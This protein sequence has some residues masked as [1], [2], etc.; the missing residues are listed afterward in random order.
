M[1]QEFAEALGAR[2]PADIPGLATPQTGYRL[3]IDAAQFTGGADSATACIDWV[4]AHGGTAVRREA[5][6]FNWAT[7]AP[8]WDEHLIVRDPS[9]PPM[10]VPVDTW[11]LHTPI[12]GFAR[13]DPGTFARAYKAATE[14]VRKG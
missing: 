8:A 6:P 13:C 1:S 11:I 10:W 9:S 5:R 14:Q 4:L 2:S 3:T 12:G 7:A